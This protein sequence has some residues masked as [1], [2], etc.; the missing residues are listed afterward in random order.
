MFNE[1]TETL[2]VMIVKLLEYI[3]FHSLQVVYMI[4]G[5]YKVLFYSM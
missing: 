2:T 1:S 4:I 3:L 5:F